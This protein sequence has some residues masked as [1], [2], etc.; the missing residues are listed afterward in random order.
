M[1]VE[2]PPYPPLARQVVVQGKVLVSGVV[3]RQGNVISAE[4]TTGHP[5]LKEVSV[6][7]LRKWKFRPNSVDDSRIEVTYVFALEDTAPSLGEDVSYDLPNH[8]RIRSSPPP[9]ISDPA[10]ILKKKHWW[11]RD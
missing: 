4:A 11:S 1:H 9:P 2:S 5:L 7:N 10:P 8:I 6:A 3:D